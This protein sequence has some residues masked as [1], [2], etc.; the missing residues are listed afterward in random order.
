MLNQKLDEER[1]IYRALATKGS[2]MYLLVKDLNKINR[3][4]RF[5][6]GYFTSLFVKC[7]EGGQEGDRVQKLAFAASALY[8][9]V[10]NSIASSLFKKD[11]M[12]FA[13]HLLHGIRS[14]LF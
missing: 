1:E 9:I 7:L 4:Y 5:S 8:K 10:Y 3:M 2:E 6:L 13:L 12:A 11:R 14:E